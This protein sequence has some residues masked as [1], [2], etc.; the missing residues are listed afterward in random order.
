MICGT[1]SR[2]PIRL[3]GQSKSIAAG[4]TTTLALKP[5]GAKN[6]RKLAKAL[7]KRKKVS[8]SLSVR[9][10]GEAGDS[11]SFTRVVKLKK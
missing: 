2:K 8:A 11:Q 1:G 10:V 3:Q 7:K 9:V 6:K 5:K 4:G